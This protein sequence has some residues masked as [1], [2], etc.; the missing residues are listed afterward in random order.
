MEDTNI[1]F[2]FKTSITPAGIEQLRLCYAKACLI[3]VNTSYYMRKMI[4]HGKKEQQVVDGC[5]ALLSLRLVYGEQRL[6]QASIRGLNGNRYNYTIIKN[7][8]FNHLEGASIPVDENPISIPEV[9]VDH[10][11]LRGAEFF[12]F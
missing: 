4:E 12:D 7:I 2:K 11:N 9:A 3:G 8:L 6:E 10:E 5:K 1:P